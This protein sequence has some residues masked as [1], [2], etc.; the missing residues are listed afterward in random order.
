MIRWNR[1]R[2]IVETR[3]ERIKR[4]GSP[5]YTWTVPATA[6]AATAVIEVGSTFPAA[7]KYQPLDFAEIVNNE[8]AID[9]LVTINGNA[10]ATLVPAM[11]IRKISGQALWHIAVTNRGGVNTTLNA[12]IV[13]LQKQPIT[14]D[15]ILRGD[16]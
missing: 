6:A 10:L 5:Y 15:R 9:I 4:E 11:S 7:K 16:V 3:L 1:Q 12:I 8:A 14:T 13:T 2:G